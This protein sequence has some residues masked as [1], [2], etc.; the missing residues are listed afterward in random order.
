MEG[1]EK[2]PAKKP[3]LIE[4]KGDNQL[5]QTHRPFSI[6]VPI[7]EEI[8]EISEGY[9]RDNECVNVNDQS[10]FNAMPYFLPDSPICPEEL[11]LYSLMKLTFKTCT[12]TKHHS[13]IRYEPIVHIISKICGVQFASSSVRH[14]FPRVSNNRLK[15]GVGKCNGKVRWVY[16]NKEVEIFTSV[17]AAELD[18]VMKNPTAI[19][20]YLL[21]QVNEKLKDICS[22]KI[23]ECGEIPLEN[24]SN[25][26]T[27]FNTM[28]KP[29]L[30]Q[31]S[32]WVPWFDP[33]EKTIHLYSFGDCPGYANKEVKI[34]NTLDWILYTNKVE[35]P[36]S[37][38]FPFKNSPKKV[39]TVKS[40]IELLQ[41]IDEYNTCEGCERSE[42]FETLEREGNSG[43]YKTKEGKN[44]VTKENG[45]FRSTNCSV[46]VPKECLQC[47]SC[48]KSQRYMRTLLSRR[49][50]QT[51]N[52]TP[53][54]KGR[55]DYMTK[56]ELLEIARE[57]A[58]T[59]KRLQVKNKRLERAMEDMIEVGPTSNS[60][61]QHIFR[62][63]YIGLEKNNEKRR[64]PTCHWENCESPEFQNVEELFRHC[65]NHIERLDTS[66]IP[67]IDRRYYCKW[68]DCT[69]SY[70]KLKLLENHVREHTGSLNDEFLEILLSDQ[71]K[72]MTTN[73]KQM[74]WHP[75]VIKWCLRI[76][77]KSHTLYEDI[78]N[79]G[80]LKL[81]SGRTLSDY[82]NFNHSDSGWHIETIQMMR[83]QF[84]SMKP[85]RHAKL[86]QLVFDEVKI[87]EGL[88]FDQKNWELVGF[89]DINEDEE[90]KTDRSEKL[91]SHVLQFF[92]RSLFFKFDYPCAFF[93]TTNL[94]ALQLNRL[95][96]LGISMLHIFEFEILVSCCD[97]ASCN[98]SFVQMNT[99]NENSNSC[100]NPFSKM[101][102]FFLSD[103]PHLIKKLRNNLHSSGFK[104]KNRRYTRSLF[105]HGKYIL[106]DHIYSVYTREQRR[107]LYVTDLRKAHVEIDSMSKMRVKLAVQTLS[108]KVANEMQE[109]EYEATEETRNY[110]KTCEKFWNVF[111]DP[112]PLNRIEDRR[113]SQLDEVIKYFKD[114][115]SWLCTQYK[116]KAMQSQHFISWQTEF[117]LEVRCIYIYTRL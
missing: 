47:S 98:R 4:S 74:R 109:C 43:I 96:W 38:V 117:D 33:V 7:N 2:P 86:G 65:K 15:S 60:D 28:I 77:I 76:Y 79:S 25:F 75:L 10:R 8:G 63:L 113:I 36:N 53:Q 19:P 84:D 71:G 56:D 94:T 13:M 88:V 103:P 80:G 85:P 40:L 115:K 62:H 27:Q 100:Q 66:V 3:R 92:F 29:H 17:C 54:Q 23:N 39:K 106:W 55:F 91:A 18:T 81:P 6:P 32:S 90:S 44:G 42:E 69:K 49:S 114:W 24:D 116:T 1:R 9:Q 102:L 34:F 57:S 68:Q 14:Y 41:L 35:R 58:G 22:S 45:T 51:A 64:K 108:T 52:V 78:R 105:L 21:F 93:L 16:F 61:L 37:S 5:H 112:K 110:I 31:S 95:F 101:P 12:F 46:L 59:I 97:G 107:H 20:E 73:P 70:S 82:K 50:L 99:A 87:N 72:A 89:T 83:K 11:L 48:N 67:P 26:A 104:E 111:N 30:L